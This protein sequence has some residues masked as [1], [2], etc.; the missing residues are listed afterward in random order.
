MEEAG[1]C[2]RLT[3]ESAVCDDEII[4][5][6]REE[7]AAMG[8]ITE[9]LLLGAGTSACIPHIACL[10]AV[11]RKCTVCTDAVNALPR[12]A[13]FTRQHGGPPLGRPSRNRRTNPSAVVKYGH[14]DGTEHALLIDCGKSF[15]QNAL[16]HMI[17]GGITKLDGVVISHGHADA[18]LGIDDLRHWA[19]IQ[20]RV[21]VWC[22]K[23]TFDVICATFPY[24]VD[25]RMATGGG[26]VSMLQFHLFDAAPASTPSNGTTAKGGGSSFVVGELT[27]EPFQVYHGC[28][29]NG[30]PYYSNGFAIEGL[31]YISDI[32]GLP[33]AAAAF[34]SSRRTHVLLVDCLFE[35]RP[36]KSHYSWLQARAL[37]DKVRPHATLLVGMAHT[38]DYYAFQRRLDAG[39]ALP[40]AEDGVV[41]KLVHA[42]GRI[43]VGFD[44]LS[45]RF[46]K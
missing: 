19:V 38:V 29:S 25:P 24:I 44:G 43:Y 34:L 3:G 26:E 12:S 16:A 39:L 14:S 33:P 1:E 37:I 7:G 2:R 32:S 45:M 20:P 11:P 41:G 31:T 9:I 27:V 6:G 30:D 13:A 8:A 21:D 4:S 15:Y 36:Y 40:L 17:R 28:H 35:E 46:E 18:I 22:D 23:S 42:P 5:L 10:M